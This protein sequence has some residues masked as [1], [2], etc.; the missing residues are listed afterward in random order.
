MLLGFFYLRP[1]HVCF[2]SLHFCW[3]R[4]FSPRQALLMATV[5]LC[6]SASTAHAVQVSVTTYAGEGNWTIPQHVP[7]PDY[8]NPT[9]IINP[10]LAANSIRS[11]V[12]RAHAMAWATS[13]VTGSG[14][15]KI[16][17][18]TGWVDAAVPNYDPKSFSWS[19]TASGTQLIVHGPTN[20]MAPFNFSIPTAAS[21]V[22]DCDPGYPDSLNFTDYHPP[23]LQTFTRDPLPY[24]TPTNSFFDLTINITAT[25]HQDGDMSHAPIDFTFLNGGYTID[26][27]GTVTPFGA[28]PPQV[29][30]MPGLPGSVNLAFPSALSNEVDLRTETPFTLDL[31]VTMQMGNG[32]N[33]KPLWFDDLTGP[34]GGGGSLALDFNLGSNP[35][36]LFTLAAVQPVTGHV[37]T[38]TGGSWASATTFDTTPNSVDATAD[39]SAVNLTSDATIT[40]DGNFTVGTLKFG[41]TV[42]S[43]NWTIAPGSP[44]GSL[45]L[46]ATTGAVIID[47]ANPT[48]TPNN[49]AFVAQSATI[50]AP[51]TGTSQFKK[52]GAGTLVLTQQNS[53]TGAVFVRNGALT[54]DF[55]QSTS[56]AQNILP[57]TTSLSLGG[58]IGQLGSAQINIIG[59]NSGL[60]NEQD[61]S[62]TT[63]DAGASVINISGNSGPMSV[64]LHGL[65]RTNF[66]SVNFLLPS[67]GSVNIATNASQPIVNGI[68]GGWATVGTGA[69]ASWATV[70]A[71]GNIAAYLAFTDVLAANPTIAS[72][73]ATNVHISGTLASVST[74]AGAQVTDINSLLTNTGV[75]TTVNIPSGATLRLGPVGGIF[76]PLAAANALTIGSG[77]SILTAGGPTLG[78]PGEL[79][80]NA[81]SAAPNQTGIVVVSKVIDNGYGG[82]VALV[83]T[84]NATVQLN[85]ANF[86]SGGTYIN[87]G[88]I[89][90][91][92]AG[93]LG[94]GLVQVANGA[95]VN[96]TASG[97]YK[98]DFAIGG[99]GFYE[100]SPQFAGGAI[101]LAANGAT[102]PVS[103]TITLLGNS[104]ISA[105]G[106]TSSGGVID[107][108]ITGGYG[109]ELGG[110]S[111]SAAA[112]GVL[113]LSSFN[114]DWQGDTTISSGTV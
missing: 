79:T 83:K 106:A 35:G 78:A 114:N 34:T 62:A 105:R 63:I 2:R 111:N 15:T 103:S 92:A 71:S 72:A 109:L 3:L 47:V 54:L 23:Q 48:A 40:L 17:S 58:S 101:R 4:N 61:F 22:S 25:V 98:N 38:A 87:S 21:L 88:A 59:G 49:S 44:A 55:S 60:A 20:T 53:F 86:Y 51:L 91:N 24:D 94:S 77:G 10:T 27:L 99:I 66:G 30:T 18:G 7:N 100:G 5:A 80:L 85:A 84:G 26:S 9:P 104:R 37:Q 81:N 14:V 45:T 50:N 93:G 74:A 56:A 8:K 67:I 41:D 1:L 64:F 13:Q 57:G 12:T 36:N 28:L 31:S 112:V 69:N 39:F 73:A 68:F 46:A 76:K 19:S 32:R 70:D 33:S 108:H 11:D 6:C 16:A 102:I 110:A 65:T 90:A 96:L 89:V 75:P 29:Q 97:N 43:N 113:T 82:K 107:A 42:P 52:T 95:E